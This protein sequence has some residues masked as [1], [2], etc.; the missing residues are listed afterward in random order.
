[1]LPGRR[2]EIIAFDDLQPGFGL[3][4]RKGG[5]RAW[6]YQYKLG[7]KQRRITLGNAKTIKLEAA[8]ASASKFHA[9]VRLGFDPAADRIER[10][11]AAAQTFKAALDV[12]LPRQKARVRPRSYVEIER[13]LDRYFRLLH[14][15]PLTKIDRRTV[16]EALAKIE[17]EHGP[18]A[19][20]RGRTTLTAF[21]SWCITEG[22]AEQ[23]PVTGTARRK[24]VARS[25]VLADA[26]LRNVWQALTDDEFSSIVR[27]LILTGQ[28]REEIGGLYWRE[29]EANL[30]RLPPE[31][32]KNKR[33]HTIPLATPARAILEKQ[34]RRN[35]RALVFGR[36]ENGFSGWSRCKARLD[37]RIAEMIGYPLPAWTLHD[38][39]RSVVTGMANI[40][41][42]PHVIEA[43]VNHISGHKAGVAGV[44]NRSKYETEKATALLMWSDHVLAV[45]GGRQQNVVPL[46][47]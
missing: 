8:R 7:A 44:Y 45:V 1:M 46:H 35:T 34:P 19:A 31:R 23:N 4:L 41:A 24:E 9:Q 29:V 27:L 26:E 28:R 12:Y 2:S 38:L 16:A 3:R 5:T 40:G 32:V 42:K 17:N 14:E 25:R 10:R 18:A 33:E 20:N 37:T 11:V 13:Y 22:I 30:I 6:V 15:W 47:A 36:G 43:V 21:C 39:R